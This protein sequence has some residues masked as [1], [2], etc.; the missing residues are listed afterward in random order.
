MPAV[1]ASLAGADLDYREIP[2]GRQISSMIEEG[3]YGAS[4]QLEIY[5]A[6]D[7][8]IRFSVS[9]AAVCGNLRAI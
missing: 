9:I 1:P 7:F 6:N 4:I 2:I 5:L 8:K 3:F